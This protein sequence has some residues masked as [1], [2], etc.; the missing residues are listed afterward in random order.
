MS[1]WATG[2]AE[3]ITTSGATITIRCPHCRGKH[4]HSRSVR[5]SRHVVAGCHTGWTRLREYSILDLHKAA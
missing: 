1:R 3:I 5:G 2:V 4:Q